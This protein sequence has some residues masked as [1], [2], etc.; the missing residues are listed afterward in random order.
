MITR[1]LASLAPSQTGLAQQAALM[2]LQ[3]Y[4]VA[5]THE[6]LR[7]VL[8]D[9]REV[10]D[11]S[12]LGPA[13][14]PGEW[15]GL[16]AATALE[17]VARV[18][19]QRFAEW[20]ILFENLRTAAAALPIGTLAVLHTAAFAAAAPAVS[21]AATPDL[22][23]VVFKPQLREVLDAAAGR[24]WSDGL[25]LS[26]RIWN[27]EHESLDGMRQVI[28]QGL[29][30]GQSAWAMARE[31][32]KYLG[33]GGGCPRWA[34][35]RLYDLT[36]GD[37]A[38]GDRTGLYSGEECDAQGVAYK[39]LRLARNEIQIAHHLATDAI[40]AQIPWI[41]DERVMLSPAHPEPDIC[42]QL[43]DG[44]EHGDGVYPKGTVLLPAHVQCLCYKV[45]VLPEADKFA[46]RL[47]GWLMGSADWPEMD[48]YA[49]LLGTT[50]S[51]LAT[52][53][54]ANM[55]ADQLVTWL[56]GDQAAMDAAAASDLLAGG[57]LALPN[58]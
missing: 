27:L 44:G 34:R 7:D 45:A 8:S 52:V 17:G 23:Q 53:S 21:E 57:Q 35:S 55:L 41:E 15:D 43:A 30:A 4:L 39:A 5:R 13:R 38:S 20:R 19:T 10:L 25:K 1:D 24:V 50:G 58:I 3:L 11:K 31:L 54:L 40:L 29:A 28:Y 26:P 9:C 49:A 51:E 33:A 6:L 2:R 42:D 56:W 14:E 36:K 37:I 22:D 48:E 12:G 16:A 32:E 47:R 46:E 18:W